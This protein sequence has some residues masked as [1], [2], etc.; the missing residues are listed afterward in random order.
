MSALFAA[1]NS[2]SEGPMTRCK[3]GSTVVDGGAVTSRIRRSR[4]S[5][6]ETIREAPI[7]RGRIGKLRLAR[8]EA[9]EQKLSVHL[10][11]GLQN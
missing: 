8:F 6:F 5:G 7:H 2:G 4:R 9:R 10:R 11:G 3:P 1:A